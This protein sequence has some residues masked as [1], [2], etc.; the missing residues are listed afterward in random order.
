MAELSAG[1][2]HPASRSIA[3][4]ASARAT[5]WPPRRTV[6]ELDDEG[7]AVV[8]DPD[9]ADRDEI[10]DAARNCPVTAIFL[11]GE[12]GDVYP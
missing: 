2:P 11:I 5:A 9:G 7:K 10:V 4:C 12:G 8:I 6:F 1:K 3:T